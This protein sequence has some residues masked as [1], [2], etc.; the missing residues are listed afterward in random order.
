MVISHP[1]TLRLPAPAQPPAAVAQLHGP[2]G[3]LL[4]RRGGLVV[5]SDKVL[6]DREAL[7]D[8]K[9]RNKLYEKLD[10]DLLIESSKA[11]VKGIEQ[12]WPESGTTPMGD[13]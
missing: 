11:I 6:V 8:E 2:V 13:R 12:R 1:W 7:I 10:K 3:A 5:S 9:Y 4:V